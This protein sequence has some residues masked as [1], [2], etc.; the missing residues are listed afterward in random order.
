MYVCVCNA[1]TDRQIRS[2]SEC[3]RGTVAEVYRAL[4]IKLQC[5]KCVRTAK[6]IINELRPQVCDTDASI[7]AFAM[8][9]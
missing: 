4:G 5:G 6:C 1:V 7:S 9:D 2:Q 8:A 3:T